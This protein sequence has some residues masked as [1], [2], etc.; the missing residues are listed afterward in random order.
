MALPKM[1]RSA[2]TLLETNLVLKVSKGWM[3]KLI[4]KLWNMAWYMWDQRNEAL[5]THTQ[6]KTAVLIECCELMNHPN[7]LQGSLGHYPLCSSLVK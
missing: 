4:K 6:S 3:A 1:A 5:H 2:R 7:L